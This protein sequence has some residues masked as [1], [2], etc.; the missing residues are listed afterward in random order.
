M[1]GAVEAV[2]AEAGAAAALPISAATAL[3]RLRRAPDSWPFRMTSVSSRFLLDAR[4]SMRSYRATP[5]IRH[6]RTDGT[7]AGTI[8]LTTDIRPQEMTDVNGTLFFYGSNEVTNA[9]GLYTSDGTS[10]GTVPIPVTS[11]GDACA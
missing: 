6:R 3:A 2:E 1:T 8:Q 5:H 7:D 9:T 4:A 11:P 10:P